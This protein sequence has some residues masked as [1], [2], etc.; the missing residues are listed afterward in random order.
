MKK[1]ILL[2]SFPL[3]IIS[4][5]K[6]GPEGDAEKLCN[7]MKD[8]IAAKEAGNTEEA[9]KLKKEGRAFGEEIEDKYK[10]DKKGWEVIETTVDECEKKYLKED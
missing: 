8:Y 4:C 5:G 9:D 7:M 1:L 3:A 10:D 2:L 6:G